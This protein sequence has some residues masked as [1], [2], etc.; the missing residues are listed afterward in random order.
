MFV[1]MA[2]TTMIQKPFLMIIKKVVR[3]ILVSGKL[4]KTIVVSMAM[5]SYNIIQLT[6]KQSGN[7]NNGFWTII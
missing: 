2:T 1:T 5:K 7:K 6:C 3:E 4:F